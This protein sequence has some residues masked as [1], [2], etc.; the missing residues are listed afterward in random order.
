MSDFDEEAERERLREKYERDQQKREATEK[1]SELLLQGATMTN[2]HCSDCGDPIFRY[3]GQEF[4]AT[5]EKAIQRDDAADDAES[6]DESQEAGDTEGEQIE[7]T[8][9]DE[10]TRVQFGGAEDT[11]PAGA[12]AED[13]PEPADP[14]T[15]ARAETEAGYQPERPADPDQSRSE[16]AAGEGPRAGDAATEPTPGDRSRVPSVDPGREPESGGTDALSEARAT[17]ERTLARQS[18]A[19]EAA[20]DPR[21]AREHLAAAREAAETLAALRR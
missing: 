19:A 21:R 8:A 17:L 7:V 18:R 16:S 4:C 15:V 14:D 9:P 1:M 12:S 10:E 13:D 20:D 5:C 11:A 6:D 3:D 2:A